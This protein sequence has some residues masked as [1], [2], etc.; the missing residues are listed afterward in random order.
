VAS[1]ASAPPDGADTGLARLAA[2]VL[3]L[4][5][6]FPLARTYRAATEIKAR[7]CTSP[8]AR[9]IFAAVGALLADLCYSGSG[10]MHAAGRN[11]F[12]H[13]K[14]PEP[15]RVVLLPCL[16]RGGSPAS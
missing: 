12:V 13:E 14:V 4:L 8:A 11:R 7:A 5:G 2:I 15:L 9:R 6:S 10:V 16:A 1:R 3:L